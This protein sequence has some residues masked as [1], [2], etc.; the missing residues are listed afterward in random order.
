MEK[1]QKTSYEETGSENVNVFD[2]GTRNNLSGILAEHTLHL[3]KPKP[4][5]R[6]SFYWL[7]MMSL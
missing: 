1:N 6:S 5:V 7:K 3:P 2:M 4:S